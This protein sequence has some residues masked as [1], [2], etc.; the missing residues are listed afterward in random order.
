M[1]LLEVLAA[2]SEFEPML[3]WQVTFDEGRSLKCKNLK[4][5]EL[6]LTN[7]MISYAEAPK[8]KRKTSKLAK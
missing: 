6:L 4:F 2:A 7:S 5:L 8:G 3:M 1:V